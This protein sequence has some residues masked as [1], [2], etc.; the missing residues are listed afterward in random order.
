MVMLNGRFAALAALSLS[1]AACHST[2]SSSPPRSADD[3][4]WPG[5]GGKADEQH[6][7]GLREINDKTIGR[8]GL[9]WSI[10]IDGGNPVSV[11]VAVDGTLYY[12]TGFAIVHAV[13]AATGKALWTFDPK[14]AS[15]AGRR[16]RQG[17]G[18]RGL[19]YDD[20]KIYVGTPDGRLIAID[21][22]GG[23]QVWSSSTVEE[24]SGLY[25]TGAPRIIGDNVL[26]G[27]G[28]ADSTA[29]R[30]YVTAYNARTGKQAW[31]F[32]IVP[33]NPKDGFES[34][35][36][37]KAAKTWSG[38]WWKQGGGGHAWNAF[39]YDAET[40][41]VYVGTGNGAPWNHHI[42]SDGKGDNLYLCSIVA[43]DAKTGKYKWHYQV[44]PGETWDYNA[45]MDMH[46]ATLTIDGKPR[47][48]LMQAPKNGFLYVID[49]ETGKVIS[50]DKVAKVTWASGI[51][52][53]TGR[54]EEN[55]LARFPDG[56]SFA[57]WP[58]AWGAHSWMPSAFSPSTGLMYIPVQEKG[59]RYSDGDI[60]TKNWKRP[61]GFGYDFGVTIA[62]DIKDPLNGTGWLVAFDPVKRKI[63]WKRQNPTMMNG[64][65]MATGGNLVF[66]GHADAGFAAYQAQNGKPLWRFDAQAPVFSAPITY[67]AKGKQYVTVLAGSGT[68][69]GIVA[70][71][72]PDDAVN[73]V[74]RV[75]TFALDGKARLPVASKVTFSAVQDPD[76]RPDPTAATS[77]GALFGR[78]CAVCHGFN[79][80]SGGTAPDLRGSQI[81]QQL[82]SFSMVVRDGALVERGM[83]RFEEFTDSEL[84]SLRQFLRS[85]AAT[86][87][88][89][90]TPAK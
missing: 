81:P 17:W 79:A 38:E 46:L 24:G 2:Q 90:Q 53:A 33:G 51:D 71:P 40:D 27:N 67:S 89:D 74:K 36:M 23:R 35:A 12:V 18:T 82:S 62:D 76:Y 86:L 48:V 20:G 32:Y 57:L 16:M 78:H 59:W 84:N 31:R 64:G 21:A 72:K 43:L 73:Q 85:R 80:I 58:S 47:K 5:Y 41:T 4:N 39:T 65:I 29:T 37:A 83:P 8:L 7:S 49:R 70:L 75:L 60:D 10:D 6:F 77:G 11:P 3:R 44:N 26:I 9:A 54:P 30:G 55:P 34:D 28:G 13:D 42:R 15:V 68:T 52:L 61:P 1:L 14:S 25:I 63:A 45:T 88:Q 66:Q 19:T 69:A 50:A 87:R 22:K 56:K